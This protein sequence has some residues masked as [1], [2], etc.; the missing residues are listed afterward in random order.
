MTNHIRT[1]MNPLFGTVFGG[2]ARRR[3]Y[4]GPRLARK[5]SEAYLG[6]RVTNERQDGVVRKAERVS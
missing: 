4:E 5:R 3:L 6:T 1:S 2:E